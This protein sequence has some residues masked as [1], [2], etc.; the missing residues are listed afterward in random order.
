MYMLRFFWEK[1]F[2]FSYKGCTLYSYH[3]GHP[4]RCDI[5]LKWGWDVVQLVECLPSI[6]ETDMGS[7][8][9]TSI[10]WVWWR[11]MPVIPEVRTAHCH[12][13][14]TSCCLFSVSQA[15]TWLFL[16]GIGAFLLG[17]TGWERGSAFLTWVWLR[18][19]YQDLR[20]NDLML[21]SLFSVNWRSW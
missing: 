11:H 5:I 17:H 8:H 15:R 4:Y 7:I 3:Q 18:A 14:P 12:L 2:V 10:Y 19:P 6:Q 13:S 9:S 1:C 16:P 21:L 20:Q